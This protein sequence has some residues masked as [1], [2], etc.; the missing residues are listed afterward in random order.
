MDFYLI[1]LGGKKFH[2]PVNPESIDVVTE[3]QIDT[4]S[5]NDIGEVDIPTGEMRTGYQFSSFFP[6]YY[7]SYC[8]YRNIP[9]PNAAIKELIRMREKGQPVRLLVSRS[10]INELVIITR[11]NPSIRGGE[12]GD[13][14]FDIEMRAWKEVKIRKTTRKIT[15]PKKPRPNPKPKRRIHVVKRGDTLWDLA[16][17]YY[18]DPFQWRKIWN[19][20]SNKSMLIKRDKRNRTNHGHW[21]YPGQ[22]LVIP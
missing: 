4:I 22:R 18:K 5:L 16:A 17:H 15:V 19:V 21:I 12:V 7:D 10:F 1:P 2:F 9:K 11:V 3:K 6:A 20:P 8:Q 13:V 14:Y